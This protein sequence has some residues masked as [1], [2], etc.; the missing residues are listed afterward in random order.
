M[1]YKEIKQLIDDMGESKLDSLKIEF[2]DGT[3]IDMTKN[4]NKLTEKICDTIK[5]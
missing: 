5:E 2:P 3:K 4:S 1:E